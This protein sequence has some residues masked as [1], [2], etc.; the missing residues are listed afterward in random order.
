M[1]AHRCLAT[2][3]YED[4]MIAALRFAQ[5]YAPEEVE[6]LLATVVSSS[7]PVRP[8]RRCGIPKRIDT[9]CRTPHAVKDP[10]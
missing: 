3:D 6:V 9:E 1:T 7:V 5:E 10:R 4:G 8:C 2:G